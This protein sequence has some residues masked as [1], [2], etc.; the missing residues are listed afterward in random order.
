MAHPDQCEMSV[1]LDLD[2]TCPECLWEVLQEL[3]AIAAG[4]HKA[5]FDDLPP[6]PPTSPAG[7]PP[8]KAA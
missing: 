1:A 3:S 4:I 8:R 7:P 6:T 2:P 5:G